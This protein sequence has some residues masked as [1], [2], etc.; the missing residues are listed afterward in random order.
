MPAPKDPEKRKLWIERMSKALT[1]T[2]QTQA[3]KDKMSKAHSGKNSGEKHFRWKG[4]E[5]LGKRGRWIIWID[6]IKYYRYR[7]IAEQCLGRKLVSDETIHH[8]NEDK[9]DDRPENLYLFAT[10]SK[11][12]RYHRWKNPPILKSNLNCTNI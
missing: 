3:T 10:H 11:H 6:G 8:I 12:M 2:T 9:L 4:K 7:Y 1:G 5:Y